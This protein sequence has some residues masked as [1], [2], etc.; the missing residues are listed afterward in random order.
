MGAGALTL[1]SPGPERWEGG[2]AVGGRGSP[3]AGVVVPVRSSMMVGV[4]VAI[5]HGD[6]SGLKAI[7]LA[8]DQEPLLPRSQIGR[9]HV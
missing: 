7:A 5:S 4:V 8:P 2:G 6:P 9:A 1:R 3:G